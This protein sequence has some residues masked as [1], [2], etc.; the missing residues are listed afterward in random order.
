MLLGAPQ[1]ALE[2]AE[3]RKR[4]YF[5]AQLTAVTRSAF[6]VEPSATQSESESLLTG[7]T[8]KAQ[9]PS[10]TVRLPN[11][12]PKLLQELPLQKG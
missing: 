3:N 7:K 5:Y 6:A 10:L 1:M 12:K 2:H 4:G 9:V 8:L 11:A